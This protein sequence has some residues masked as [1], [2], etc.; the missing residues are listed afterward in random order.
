M[1]VLVILG[2]PRNDSLC[3]ALFEAFR[4]GLGDA[5]LEFRALRVA[6]LDFDPDVHKESPADQPLEPDLQRAQE[7]IAWAE[8]LVFVYPTWWGTLP[9]RLKAFLDRTLTPGFAFRHRSDGTWERRLTG[10]TAQLLTTMDTPQWV[11]RWIYGAPGHRALARATLGFCGVRTVRKTVFG[12]VIGSDAARRE[13]WLARARADGRRLGS[14]PL[15]PWQRRR[16]RALAWV[17]ALRLQFY[18]MTWIAYTVGALAAAR[19]GPLDRGAYWL[20]YGALFLLEAAT[21]FSNDY[22]DF[23][24]D[25]RNR[26]AGPFSGGS[27]VLVDGSLRF[28]D[29][30]AG[31]LL[32]L[33]GFA[34]LL[35]LAVHTAGA[36]AAAIGVYLVLALLAL[37]YTVP[38]AKLCHRGWG[39]ADVALTHS[40]GVILSGYLLQ[41]GSL[42]DPL[43]WQLATALFFAV[44]PAIILS[45]VPDYDADRAAGKR[46]L[47]VKLG[48]RRAIG[49]AM[50]S[51]G[52]AAVVAVAWRLSGG[53]GGAYGPV[54]YAVVPH[55][56]LLLWRMDRQRR[57]DPTRIDGLMA[58]ALAYIVWFGAVPLAGLL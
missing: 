25:R 38:P 2:H 35:P 33:A 58:L 22:F 48:K 39:E 23:E 3:G 15:A 40:V 21:V 26:H 19:P 46:T 18:P 52:I 16:D 50:L 10:R 27:R 36:G 14:G 6:D 24:S 4:A 31:T 49:A 45:G 5:G 34:A 20:G 28:R 57:R 29:M 9:A 30:A 13:A 7:S 56:A 12:P 53:A 37:G 11:Y 1:R 47:V 42:G 43:P 54:V 8:H 32:A 55:A 44:L 51:T 17:R 41:G